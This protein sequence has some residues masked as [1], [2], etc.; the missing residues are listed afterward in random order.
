MSKLISRICHIFVVGTITFNKRNIYIMGGDVV[1]QNNDD[2]SVNQSLTVPKHYDTSI[3]L[4]ELFR[5]WIDD[6]F[7]EIIIVLDKES[8][9]K[10]ISSSVK[11]TLGYCQ[12]ELIDEKGY[13][14]ISLED[15]VFI[16]ERF[17]NNLGSMEGHTIELSIRDFQ[18][19]YFRFNC[20]IDRVNVENVD[21]FIA[22]LVDIRNRNQSEDQLVHSEKMTI[23]GQFAAGIAHEIRNPLTSLKG[24][25]QLLQSGI[26]QKDAYYRIMI[27]EID[28]LE[29]ITS[30]LLFISRP[31]TDKREME[32]VRSMV[33]DVMVLLKSQAKFKNINWEFIHMDDKA[34]NCDRSQIKQ[35]LINVIK[36]AIEAIQS[37]GTIRISVK[38]IQSNMEICIKDDGVGIPEEIIHKIN[39]PFFTTKDS[40]TGLGLMISKQILNQHHGSMSVMPNSYGGCTV[41]IILP[42]NES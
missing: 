19:E 12:K 40:G 24:F 9:I 35:V 21:Y 11:G 27:E 26:A 34:I 18:G 37:S 36:N 23:A 41:K 2:K 28:K 10:Y 13:D 14:I 39:E 16:K 38:E 33:D 32:S 8:S 15:K 4:S 20:H 1:C 17:K 6:H 29:S 22:T 42:I 3:N 25:L 5:K 7:E 31:L 30:E